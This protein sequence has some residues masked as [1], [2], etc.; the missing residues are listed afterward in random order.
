[1]SAAPVNAYKHGELSSLSVVLI[2][3]DNRSPFKLPLTDTSQF[4]RGLRIEAALSR[5]KN[6][7]SRHVAIT[8]GASLVWRL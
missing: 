1:M 5:E 4:L 3:L 2:V 8:G 6:I 7:G